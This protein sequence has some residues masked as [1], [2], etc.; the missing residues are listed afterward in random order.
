MVMKGDTIVYNANAFELANGSMLDALISLL[1]GVELNN[2]QIFVNG[3]SKL[4]LSGVSKYLG[5][6]TIK[7]N[8][9]IPVKKGDEFNLKRDSQYRK[10]M[11]SQSNKYV[12]KDGAYYSF[13]K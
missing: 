1:P 13:S 4:N 8:E 5:Y 7:L 12:K 6:H 9:Y 2:G 10:L 3:E 11:Q